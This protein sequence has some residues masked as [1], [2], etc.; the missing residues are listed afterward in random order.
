MRRFWVLGALWGCTGGG[1]PDAEDPTKESTPVEASTIAIPAVGL[2]VLVHPTDAPSQGPGIVHIDNDGVELA[3]LPLPDG[4]SSPH[5]LAFDG[6]SLWLTDAAEGGLYEIDPASGDELS[7]L[8]IAPSQGVAVDGD[9]FWIHDGDFIRIDA[10]GAE[11]E[12]RRGSTVVQDLAFDGT[13]VLFLTNG[14]RDTVTRVAPDDT[15]T[16]LPNAVTRS[17]TGYAMMLD[18]G[19]LYVADYALYDEGLPYVDSYSTAVLRTVDPWT[20]EILGTALLPVEGWITAI[21]PGELP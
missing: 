10:T 3:R 18:D 20:G 5:G 19:M 12:R 16:D 17:N 9:A 1:T 13:D 21:A 15:Q 6:A 2:W 14:D 4:V 8:P 11:T 7:F